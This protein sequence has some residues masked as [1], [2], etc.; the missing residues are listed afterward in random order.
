MR[1]LSFKEVR[2]K[3]LYSRAHLKRLEDAGAFPRRVPLGNCRVGWVEA[4]VE[5]WMTRRV[6]ERDKHTGSQ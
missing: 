3:V 4:E 2:Q 5:D 6:A 1:F